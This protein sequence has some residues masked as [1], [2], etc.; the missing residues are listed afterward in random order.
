M[1]IYAGI[2]WI[3]QPVMFDTGDLWYEPP[4]RRKSQK[5]QLSAQSA[6]RRT[7]RGFD[8]ATF[9]R[10]WRGSARSDLAGSIFIDGYIM[11]HI[12]NYNIIYIY[13]I[14]IYIH[15]NTYIY[16]YLY[17]YTYIYLYM[18]TFV[19]LYIIVYIYT[20]IYIYVYYYI[21]LYIYIHICILL[22][23]L[24]YILLYIISLIYISLPP[25]NSF[26]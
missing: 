26:N 7:F 9:R 6:W 17:M 23:I 19:Y 1:I 16:I 10:M 3:S 22:Y 11:V 14:H 18:Y 4:S 2:P 13:I 21:Y 5:S 12:C 15:I 25:I 8:D 20:Y 24:I